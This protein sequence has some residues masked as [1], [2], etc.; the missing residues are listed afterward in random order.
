MLLRTRPSGHRPARKRV[1]VASI[2]WAPTRLGL[3]ISKGVAEY[4]RALGWV[5]LRFDNQ[6]PIPAAIFRENGVAGF[7]V[8]AFADSK[9]KELLTLRLPAVNVSNSQQDVSLPRV[10]PDDR[11]VGEMAAEYFLRRGYL[12]FAFCGDSISH[13]SEIRGRGYAG[14]LRRYGG[15]AA[16]LRGRF[17]LPVAY[18]GNANISRLAQWLARLPKPCALFAWNDNVCD[19]ILNVCKHEGI[20]VPEE[21]SLLGVNNDFNRLV[22]GEDDSISSIE[23]AGHAI[24]YE[25][26]RV[27]DGI[28]SGGGQPRSPTYIP[29]LRI[30]E[31]RSTDFYAVADTAVQAALRFIK[32]N[33]QRPTGVDEIAAAAMLSRRVLEKRFRSLFQSSPYDEVLRCRL[34][35]ARELLLNTDLKVEEIAQLCGY[36]SGS[37]FSIF[38]SERSGV[39]P[40][41]FRSRLV[42][43]PDNAR[44]PP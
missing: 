25:A 36:D 23:L 33:Y 38:F 42:I 34:E 20:S 18:Q 5:V 17:D 15:I 21:I 22:D 29:P 35:R 16:V 1:T 7:I 10:A 32:R 8:Q 13:C 14:S 2:T 12:N 9:I 19:T 26:A 3:E 39:S 31:R 4:G 41:D 6:A 28:L 11:R 24:G 40:K 30:V 43:P 27:L 44:S 37:N